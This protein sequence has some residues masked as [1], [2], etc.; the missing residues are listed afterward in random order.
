MYTTSKQNLDGLHIAPDDHVIL[1]ALKFPS[2][3]LSKPGQ[4]AIQDSAPDDGYVAAA[5]AAAA[6]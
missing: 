3:S 4:R 1:K 5:A 2:D 6:R